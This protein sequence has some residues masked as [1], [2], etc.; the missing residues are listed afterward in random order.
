MAGIKRTI[1]QS[2]GPISD[3]THPSRKRRVDYSE[4]DAQQAK[5]YNDLA[6]EIPAVRLKAAGTL[7]KRLSANS[8]SQVTSIREAL[9]RLVKGLCSGRKAARLGFSIALSEVLR[10]A[11]GLAY[12]HDA[13]DLRLGAITEQVVRLTEAESKAG[14]QEKREYLLGRRFAFQATLQSDVAL[15]NSLSD[16]DWQAFLAAIA[17][18]AKQK[19]WLRSECGA[20]LNEYLESVDVNRLSGERVQLVVS[21]L[22]EHQLLKT[23]EG[24]ALWLSIADRW[25]EALP[26]D[27]W[28]KKD[29]LSSDELLQVKKIMQ[30]SS[31]DEVQEQATGKAAKGGTRQSQPSFA[32]TVILTH[33]YKRKE[34]AFRRFWEESVENGL[35]ASASSAERKSLG[36]QI[37]CM[38][39]ATAPL[40]QLRHVLG[41]NILRTI[42]N[43]RAE[44]GRTLFEAV[45]LPLDQVAAR[46][47]QEPA[48]AG[49]LLEALLAEG[50]LDQSTKTKTIEAVVQ[51]ASVQALQ[52]IVS[53]LTARILRPTAESDA[54][55]ESRRRA[56]ADILL[57][58]VRAH[59]EPAL[60]FTG[61]G[62]AT[63]DC[64]LTTWV[65]QLLRALIECGYSSSVENA[66]P[67]I[68]E[69]NSSMF[70]ARLM[71][72]L[73]VLMDQAPGKA[74]KASSYVVDQLQ[75]TRERL[76]KPLNKQAR[77]TLKSAQKCR[78]QMMA[79]SDDVALLAYRLL[80]DLSIVPV[81]DE[82]AD[83]IEALQDL[84]A[85]FQARQEGS[86]S[87]TM[88]VEL[89]LSFVSKSSAVFRKLAERVFSTFA[90][91]LTSESLQSL[92]DI[93]QQKESLSGQQALFEQ[94]DDAEAG[95][96]EDDAEDDGDDLVDV[97]DMSDVELANGE[98][99]D[100]SGADNSE[101][102]S[103]ASSDADSGAAEEDGEDEEAIFDRKLAA[104]LGTT[105]MEEDSD[106]DGSEMDDEQMLALEPH[107]AN[108]FKERKKDTGKKQENKDAKENIVNFKNRVLDLLNIYVKSQYGNTLA[109]DLVL[110]LTA[111]VR[112]TSSKPTAEKAFAVLKQYFEACNKHKA[113]PQPEDHEACFELLSELHLEL[114]LGGSKLHGN[115]CSR[116]SLFLSKMLVALDQDHYKRI[117][118]MY[119]ELQSEWYMDAKSKVQGS[120]FTEWTSWSLATRKQQQQK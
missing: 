108:I 105:G 37:V 58:M 17:H 38:A 27:V 59:R 79:Q 7:L 98:V 116:S 63:P 31:A 64:G 83:G 118:S 113:L 67:A 96:D 23:A 50:A 68:S 57:S 61:D 2:E 107:L 48:A 110:P 14:G 78:K 106:E 77:E 29:P 51:N 71:S 115:A 119:A 22:R 53:T 85:S 8:S 6:D 97:D 80:F 32:W 92:L 86:D 44:P 89:L 82:E 54:Q 73:S 1:A 10:L 21:V 28:H 99:L 94:K 120:V 47:K 104:A 114:K 52:E 43:H 62:S 4:A 46:V 25:P 66:T 39:V 33:L 19:A 16:D 95:S 65:S 75:A 35:F 24:L 101:E 81:Y 90:S 88:L 112:T 111:L 84:I 91:E 72:C 36:L 70:R 69:G 12:E 93:L 76:Q 102:D 87:A 41:R 5:T 56:Y 74:I 15:I 20:M 49:Q 26:K 42:I 9:T 60:L 40:A 30:G 45:K 3:S 103:D 100:G 11:F 34:K 117:A 55:T 13:H 18:L 109:V